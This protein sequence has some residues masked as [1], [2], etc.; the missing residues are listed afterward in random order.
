MRPPRAPHR[1]ANLLAAGM[2][3]ESYSTQRLVSDRVKLRARATWVAGHGI[4]A[5]FDRYPRSAAAPSGHSTPPQLPFGSALDL[6]NLGSFDAYA[7]H[8]SF[9][10]EDE[11]ISVILQRGGGQILCYAFVYDDHGGSN[12]DFPALRAVD[13]RH[14][15]VVHQETH[16]AIRL[17]SGLK[18]HEA[19][20][21]L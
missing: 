6:G 3:D 7:C 1:L 8:Q 20:T 21:E 10:I 17:C 11:R 13:V 16:I 18:S 14:G 19:E 2:A 15:V 4:A 5:L 9:L 12:A